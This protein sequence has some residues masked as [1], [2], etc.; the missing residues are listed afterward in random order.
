[1]HAVNAAEAPDDSFLLRDY[2]LD[3]QRQFTEYLKD[4]VALDR[5]YISTSETEHP[6]TTHFSKY[7]VRYSTHYYAQH[8]E[9]SMFTVVHESGHAQYELNTGDELHRTRLARGTSTAIHES[10][11]RFFE[12]MIGRTREFCTL[13]FPKLVEL[14]PE[15]LRGVDAEMFYRAVNKSVPSLVRTKADELT[16]SLHVMIRYEIEKRLFDGTLKAHDVP[17]VW[18]EMYREYLGIEVPDDKRGCLQDM[19]WASGMFGYFPGYS[20]GS[21]YAAQMYANMLRYLDVPAIIRTG[22]LRPVVDWLTERIYKYGALLTPAEV[23]Q[24]A[25]EAQFDPMYYVNYL[26]DKYSDLYGLK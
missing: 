25:C 19:H 21:A 9:Y 16:Y 4:V 10:Q 1:M 24:S 22:S 8:P 2:P 3:R 14:F 7:D 26:K 18:A 11:S 17:A 15:Q 5:R 13:V 23:L 6:F 12:N 20:L